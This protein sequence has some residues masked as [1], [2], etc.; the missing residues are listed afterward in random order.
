MLVDLVCSQG[1]KLAHTTKTK[2]GS[3]H[4]MAEGWWVIP[5]PADAVT[6]H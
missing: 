1:N 6:C 5:R 2:V 3:A 4:V